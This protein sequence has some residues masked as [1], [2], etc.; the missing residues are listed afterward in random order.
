MGRCLFSRY[1]S[2]P[3]VLS[4]YSNPYFF[5]RRFVISCSGT[6]SITSCLSNSAIPSKLPCFYAC[7]AP[8]GVRRRVFA[9]KGV[10]VVAM[11]V[12]KRSF[13]PAFLFKGPV[14]C[15][16]PISEPFGT[17]QAFE[18]AEKLIADA[19]GS[20]LLIQLLRQQQIHEQRNCKYDRYDILCKDGL[21]RNR[22][23]LPNACFR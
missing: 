18:C 23:C 11:K 3:P 15:L 22:K 13:L 1:T 21:D 7:A 9:L 12:G 4:S 19:A 14:S 20:S 17:R 10:Y 16:C 8:K 2:K 6:H 5:A